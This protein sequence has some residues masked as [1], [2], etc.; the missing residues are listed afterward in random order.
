MGRMCARVRLSTLT[1]LV[2]ALTLAILLWPRESAAHARLQTASPA[3]NSEL[4]QSPSE[5]KLAFTEPIEV[6]LSRITVRSGEQSQT[7]GISRVPGDPRSCLAA[8]TPL[9]PGAYVV[10]WRV[11]SS[12]GHAM[13]GSYSFTVRERAVQAPAVAP[14]VAQATEAPP[15]PPASREEMAG[16]WL[17]IAGVA[18]LLGAAIASSFGLGGG[19]DLA[20]ATV[21]WGLAT[22]GAAVLAD[23]ERRTAAASLGALAGTSIGR[24]LMWRAAAL[25]AA[26]VLLIVARAAS[27]RRVAMTL[28]AAC[29]LMA[30]V[31]HA[32]AGHAGAVETFSLAAIGLQSVHFAAAGVWFGGLATLLAGTRGDPD[33]RKTRAVR[34]YSSLAGLAL[35][36]VA[37][38]GILRAV[39]ELSSWHQLAATPYGQAA[40]AKGVLL[41]S[42]AAFGALNRWQSVPVA[43]TGLRPLRRFALIELALMAAALGVAAILAT[44]APPG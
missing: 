16:R 1:R 41:V 31:V 26:A 29:A 23:A 12:D 24:A 6:R 35:A 44:L 19:S 15:P 42:I 10:E 7:P 37:V 5:I 27:V 33:P 38:T 39:Q 43:A 11:V 17:F 13:S 28:A 32:A 2:L 20:I 40:L 30:I 18:L 4:D 34:R 3:P 36:I 25:A 22:V 8:L 21:G 9:R 14:P